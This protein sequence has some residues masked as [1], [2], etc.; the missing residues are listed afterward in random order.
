MELVEG[1]SLAQQLA[2]P[3]Q[4]ARGAAELV[5][6][7]AG[8]VQFAHQK[9]IIHRDLKPANIL[10]TADGTLKITDFG[11]AREIDG[12][13]RFT[14]PGARVGTPRYMAPEQ[15]LGKVSAIGPAVDIYALG[16]ILYELLTGQPPFVA[17]SPSETERQVIADEP[18]PLSRLNPKV[19]RDL[20]TICLKCLQKN[21]ARRYAS[22]G[23]GRRSLPLSRWQAGR[24]PARGVVE[25][26]AKWAR[27]RPARPRH[28]RVIR[29]ACG[30]QRTGLW[31]HRAKA[32]AKWKRRVASRARLAIESVTTRPTNREKR[33]TGRRPM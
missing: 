20:E 19:P 24:R 26:T 32:N 14:L 22:A 33:S 9:G 18:L 2:G 3:P 4:S 25:R 16:A 7:L 31:L 15:A 23:S 10:V 28:R 29:V 12:D 6:T 13:D 27:W 21:P 11:L 5:G 17:E 30:G 1:G 8:A